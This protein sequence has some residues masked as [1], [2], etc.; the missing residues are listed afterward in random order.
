MGKITNWLQKG[1]TSNSLLRL[2]FYRWDYN[3]TENRNIYLCKCTPNI[4]FRNAPPSDKATACAFCGSTDIRTDVTTSWRAAKISFK[5]IY[6]DWREK[7]DTKKY[8]EWKK[9][10]GL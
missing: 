4:W 10:S 5:T 6:K 1:R 2:F 3:K 7:R 9:A 8:F